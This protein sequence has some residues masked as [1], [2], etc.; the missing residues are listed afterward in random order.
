MDAPPAQARP[1]QQDRSQRPLPWGHEKRKSGCTAAATELSGF[2]SHRATDRV[3]SSLYTKASIDVH[4]PFLQDSDAPEP[5]GKGK[6]PSRSQRSKSS[7]VQQD[8][9]SGS[10]AA[11]GSTVPL[12]SSSD[13]SPN[14]ETSSSLLPPKSSP[15]PIIAVEAPGLETSENGGLL[16]TGADHDTTP[17]PNNPPQD[18]PFRWKPLITPWTTMYRG[19]E[20]RSLLEPIPSGS[21]NNLKMEVEEKT[22]QTV[23]WSDVSSYLLR[24]MPFGLR[25]LGHYRLWKS[26]KRR[27]R[28]S[29]ALNLDTNFRPW[30]CWK[31]SCSPD[32][33]N[34]ETNASTT[35][36]GSLCKFE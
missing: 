15:V 33:P 4:H 12:I 29:R 21:G 27:Y 6:K 25:P 26:F 36:S 32:Q 18:E 14:P 34:Q 16:A 20:S 23:A 3:S 10:P 28:S 1:R 22:S 30:A 13:P 7:T 24:T 8:D 9:Q 35:F 17:T 11:T 19:Y 31:R 2:A 5:P